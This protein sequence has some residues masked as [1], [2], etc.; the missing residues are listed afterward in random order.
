MSPVIELSETTFRRLQE[1]AVPFVDTPETVIV[2][3]L[4][5]GRPK[6][7][8]S[9]AVVPFPANRSTLP[10]GARVLPHENHK[11]LAHTKIL[12]GRF[13]Q[14]SASNWNEL[15]VKAH[16]EARERLGSFA[17]VRNASQSSI[18]EGKKDDSGFHFQ[19]DI[20]LSIQYVDANKAWEQ[21]LSLAKL[22]GT[23]VEVQFRW[24]E[25]EGAKYPGEVGILR[26]SPHS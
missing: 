3:M 1:L 9:P 15:L 12:N 7:D 2:R 14:R 21:I 6:I 17:A 13:G 18:V 8:L 20:N 25:K 23:A 4:D 19:P 10:A 16:V 24:R 22:L 11:D 26:W 5:Q